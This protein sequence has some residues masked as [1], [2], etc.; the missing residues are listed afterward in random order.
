MNAIP[1][2]NVSEYEKE[3][4]KGTQPHYPQSAELDHAFLLGATF[5]LG[6]ILGAMGGAV[7]TLWWV[8]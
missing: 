1:D 5:A 8:S 7:V 6:A 2:W 3:R 4:R